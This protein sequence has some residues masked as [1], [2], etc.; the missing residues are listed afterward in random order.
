MDVYRTPEERFGD[1]PG[2]PY[3][4][5]YFEWEGL[6]LHYVDEGSGRPILLLHGEPDWSYLYRRMLPIL[7]ARFRVVAPDY[8]GFGRSDKPTDIGWYSYDRH[9]A[10]VAALIEHLGLE[11]ITLVVQDWGGPIGLRAAVESRERFARLVVMNTGLFTGADWP[12]PGFLR[13]RAFA[14]RTGLDLPVGRVMEA[15]VVRPLDQA[16][17][18]AYEAPWP[19]RESKAGV[20][21]FPLLVPISQDHPDAGVL[22]GVADELR[23]WPVPALVAWSDQDP[24]FT[25]EHGRAMAE[26]LPGADGVWVVEGAGHMLQEDRGEAIAERIVEWMAR[27]H[28]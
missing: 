23:A 16:T 14:E 21:A 26:A 5:N 7:A 10:S 12:T 1:L 24:V 8:A 25:P 13:W 2:Y 6:R 3:R 17:L 20:A 15:S 11:A 22:R 9:V 4:P 27:L 18:A 28:D 19:V